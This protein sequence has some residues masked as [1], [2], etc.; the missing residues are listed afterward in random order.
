MHNFAQ[1]LSVQLKPMKE[2]IE[3]LNT[4][5]INQQEQISGIRSYSEEQFAK[6]NAKI[7][8][9]DE[10]HEREIGKLRMEFNDK[11]KQNSKEVENLRSST[12]LT[13]QSGEG[14]SQNNWIQ[15]RIKDLENQIRKMGSREEASER[16]RT[17]FLKGFSDC[18]ESEVK[19]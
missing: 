4:N 17:M 12:I 6:M 2:S 18:E 7:D 15:D 16:A 8:E 19:D 9:V 1:M 13:N 5:I 10:K 11:W 14:S 3:T